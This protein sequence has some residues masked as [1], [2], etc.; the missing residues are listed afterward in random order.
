MM[1]TKEER[2]TTYTEQQVAELCEKCKNHG[3]TPP[4]GDRYIKDT[5]FDLI[6][7]VINLS[8]KV[9]AM[10]VARRE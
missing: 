3:I 1:R 6:N 4:C 9:R 8:D 10:E 5:I 2:F 7:V